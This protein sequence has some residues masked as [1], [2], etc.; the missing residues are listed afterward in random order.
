[1]L[2]KV[3]EKPASAGPDRKEQ[4][5]RKLKTK[6]A[7][8]G[9][10]GLGYVGLPLALTYSA[11]GYRTVG[12]DLDNGKVERLNEGK[13][14]IEHIKED[15]IQEAVSRG[16]EA[17]TD[18]SRVAYMD[19]LI[20][21]VPTPL[22]KHRE[23]DMRY[24]QSTME[25]ILPH[26]RP[27]QIISLESTTYP[28]TTEEELQPRIES[29]GFV[30]GQD[31]FL[32]HSPERQDPGNPKFHTHNIPKVCGGATP[33]CLEVGLALYGQVIEK[34]VPVSSTR[35]AELTKLLENIQRVVNIGLMN[36]MKIV[37]DRMGIDIYE[38]IRAAST[39]PFG[40]TPYW[41]GPGIGG[42]CIP[43]DPFYLTWKVREYHV[44]TRFIELAGEINSAM[45][46]WV[47][48]KISDALNAHGKSL[49]NS[50]LL[51]LGVAY[52]KNVDDVRESPVFDILRLLREKGARVE[53]SDPHVPSLP[54]GHGNDV[55][56]TSVPLSPDVLASFD[57]VVIT[58]DH[59][60]YD[61]PMIR[62]AAKLIVDTRGVYPVPHE[63][64]F[65][66]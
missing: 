50:R 38:V 6:T 65:R 39:K 36:E 22:D 56:L 51:I 3:L 16:F 37:A 66:A 29:R 49:K 59:D 9:V 13:T 14:Y 32:V 41:P 33:E 10:V 35:V 46:H 21:C 1:M 2:T 52:K 18:M 31:I 54:Q 45:P 62:Q 4:L 15:L 25:N 19:A 11:K 60:A 8:I 27:G 23:P 24:I 20:L 5:V 43:V 7:S 26:I 48:G 63:K 28:G 17:T 58:T 34:V 64:I 55:A 44:H 53:Y 61:F 30:V 47:C 12:F 42:H 40:F 57:G